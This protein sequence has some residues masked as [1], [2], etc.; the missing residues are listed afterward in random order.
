MRSDKVTIVWADQ[1]YTPGN[2][3]RLVA[4]MEFPNNGIQLLAIDMKSGAF[5]HLNPL[6]V[7]YDAAGLQPK[8][9]AREAP[10]PKNDLELLDKLKQEKEGEN[11]A[12]NKNSTLHVGEQQPFLSGDNQ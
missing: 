6:V 2:V 1:I 3:F 10:A 9:A 4:I 11:L 8:Q 12:T 7:S 5:V